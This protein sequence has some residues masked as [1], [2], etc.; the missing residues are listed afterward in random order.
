[1]LVALYATEILVD[2]SSQGI[3]QWPAGGAGIVENNKGSGPPT[4]GG[5]T[6]GLRQDP[7]DKANTFFRHLEN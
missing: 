6:P 2:R 4:I 5:G 7:A 1:L 3:W